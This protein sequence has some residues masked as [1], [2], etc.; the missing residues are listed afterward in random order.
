MHD[1]TGFVGRVDFAWPRQCVAVEYGGRW[2][3]ERQNVDRDRRRRN[4]ITAA[5]WTGIFATAEDLHDPVPLVARIGAVLA[6]AL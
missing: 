2:R 4:R 5:G 3:G 1:G 6:A